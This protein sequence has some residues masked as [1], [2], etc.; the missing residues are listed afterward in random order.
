MNAERAA[1]PERWQSVAA[2]P[3]PKPQADATR[4]HAINWFVA[5]TIIAFCLG[6]TALVVA[7]LAGVR[8]Q[9]VYVGLV[10]FVSFALGAVVGAVKLISYTNE[11]RDW[12]YSVESWT[13]VDVDGDG[14]IGV[15]VGGAA[16]PGVLVRGVDNAL[17]R[18]DTQLTQT[19]LSA[20]KRQMLTT[21]A[22][23]VRAVNGILHDE[24][25]ASL[26]RAELHRLG[27]LETPQPRTATRLTDPGV[28]AVRRWQD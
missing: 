25:R 15:P 27:I 6:E 13:G 19:E 10:A 14:V 11:H 4:T 1:L 2:P 21:G 20:I 22:F 28:H 17:H 18:I 23:G 3:T 8:L 16:I 12:L 26:L 5:V 9:V 7:T 24:T